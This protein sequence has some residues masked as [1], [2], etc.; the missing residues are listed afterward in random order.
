MKLTLEQK[1][2]R[3]DPELRRFIQLCF[4]A[5]PAISDPRDSRYVRNY[6]EGLLDGGTTWKGA[7]EHFVT[8]LHIALD[9]HSAV[10]QDAAAACAMADEWE[11]G[12]GL[13][14]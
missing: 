10:S 9:R 4:A 2:A 1:L 7:L 11:R 8:G 14:L 6:A 12:R 3:K 5:L 13:H